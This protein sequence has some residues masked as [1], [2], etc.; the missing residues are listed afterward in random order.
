MGCNWSPYEKLKILSVIGGVPHYIEEIQPDLSTNENLK[1]IFFK[2]NAVLLDEFNNIFSDL[3]P[4]RKKI[5][6]R[7]IEILV[8]G[9]VDFNTICKKLNMPKSGLVKALM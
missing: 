2:E 5:Y 7:I 9:A 8:S 4:Y 1:K 3:F 6:K